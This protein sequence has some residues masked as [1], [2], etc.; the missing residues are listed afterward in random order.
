MDFF[1]RQKPWYAGQF[2][3]KII[4]KIELT[5]N[6][7]LY[8][9]VLLNKQKQK[10]LSI[11]VRDVDETLK[12]SKISLPTKNGEIDFEFMENF[13][14]E[15]EAER[16]AEL[17]AY[18]VA[19]RLN[20]YELTA[21]E[22]KA[23]EDFESGKFERGEFQIGRLLEKLNLKRYK[24]PFNKILDTSTVQSDEFNLPLINAK[25][26][27]NGIM[28]YGREKDFDSA[29]MTIDIISNGAVAT[30]TVY[31]QIK[32]VGVLWDAYLLK[33]RIKKLNKEELLFLTTSVQKSIKTKFGWENK[34]VWSKVQHELF[35]LLTTNKKPNFE[36][37]ETFISAIQKL[38]IRDVVLYAD[39]KIAATKDV[40]GK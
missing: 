23:L 9:S 7:I 32:A 20:T 34:A 38:V 4:P 11:L 27:D 5:K 19:S 29:E 1:Y 31:A 16:V 14:A 40:L 18:L 30:G 35:S 25:I 6:S 24:K 28:F 17:E 3:R 12:N 36:A 10:L 8:F 21:E 26:G 13:I 15:L 39:K 37:M 22:E 33:S 2:V